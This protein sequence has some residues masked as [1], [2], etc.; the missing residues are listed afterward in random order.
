MTSIDYWKECISC[1]AEECGLEITQEQLESIAEC[2]EGGHDNYGMAFYS[3]PPSDRMSVIE[4]EWKA[5]LKDKEREL[6]RYQANAETAIKLALRQY[7]D[8][9]VSIGEYGE[10]LRHDGRT[11]RI[12]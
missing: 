6:E 7:S 3:P 2:V 5:K 10:V 9:N 11:E 12:Q 1:A 4:S 8:A